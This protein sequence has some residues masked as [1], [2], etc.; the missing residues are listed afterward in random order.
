MVSTDKIASE[1][2]AERTIRKAL[3]EVK[4]YKRMGY[5]VAFVMF[6]GFFAWMA[7]VPLRSAIMADGK[8]VTS[9]SN[10]VVQHPSGGII[11]ELKVKEGDLVEEG[12]L[13][14]RLSD[15]QVKSQLDI[16]TR[17]WLD[18]M[19]NLDRLRAERDRKDELVWSKEVMNAAK[20]YALDEYVLTQQSLF[21][22]RRESFKNEQEIFQKRILQTKQQVIGLENILKAQKQ[23]Y[24]SISQDLQDWQKLYEKH[25][26]DKVKVRE[27]QRQMSDLEGEMASRQAELDRLAQSVLETQRT[28]SQRNEESLKEI[29]E[30]I[31][32]FQSVM[33][34]SSYQRGSLLDDL[35]RLNIS[36]TGSG[37]IVGLE[38]TTVG[39]LVEGRKTLMQ[40]VPVA[41]QFTLSAKIKPTDVDQVFV[42]QQAEIKFTAF[43]L[44]FVPV[45]YG[46]VISVGADVLPDDTDRKMYYRIRIKIP[47]SAITEMESRGWQLVPGMPATAFLKTRERTLLNYFLRP[48]QLMVM[49][50]FNE[51][52]GI[53]Q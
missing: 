31:K 17:R 23:R 39:A 38:M 47:E 27:F 43:R 37:R 44:N 52:D 36:A 1:V 50:A 16:V 5:F 42:G 11:A 34:E 6:F 22:A 35:K 12:Q 2:H 20:D 28:A 8:V 46:E 33:A 40:I 3:Y 51:D 41:N 4:S 48:F 19:V 49:N 18:A 21:K 32:S 14:I 9:V 53:N 25:F 26:T 30:Q 15:I 24:A 10:K 29:S 13:L 7:L 45:M